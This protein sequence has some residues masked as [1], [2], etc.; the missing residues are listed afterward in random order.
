MLNIY[1][2]FKKNRKIIC[3][4][5]G[6]L[7]LLFFLSA[8]QVLIHAQNNLNSSL[9]LNMLL[10]QIDQNYLPPP[11]NTGIKDIA[12]SSPQ[13]YITLLGYAMRKQETYLERFPE[14]SDRFKSLNSEII[15]SIPK[16]TRTYN[17]SVTNN[18]FISTQSLEEMYYRALMGNLDSNFKQGY[19]KQ[20]GKDI[21]QVNMPFIFNKI[22]EPNP[23]KT[24]NK[25]DRIILLDVTAP[26]SKDTSDPEEI[27][28]IKDTI[29]TVDTEPIQE[30]NDP[31]EIQEY[32]I[33]TLKCPL[34]N[35]DKNANEYIE[36]DTNNN[37]DDETY[38]RCEYDPEGSLTSQTSFTEGLRHGEQFNFHTGPLQVAT[39]N[40]EDLNGNYYG[41]IKAYKYWKNEFDIMSEKL[42]G[43]NEDFKLLDE[44]YTLKDSLQPEPVI[45]SKSLYIKGI[46]TE[47]TWFYNNGNMK[48]YVK[49]NTKDGS[50]IKENCWNED[51][52]E[53]PCQKRAEK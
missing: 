29:F 9:T 1:P 36:I 10:T 2:G 27:T 20:F 22:E 45:S 40:T 14:Y 30:E 44:E 5:P 28:V 53:I 18:K 12:K 15:S 11:W 24:V 23:E 39:E 25:D 16:I 51:G 33:T 37:P 3:L 49:I 4:K 50:T 34:K 32:F 38:I 21:S 46:K 8:N 31:F 26:Y 13:L 43:N 47:T 6:F 35:T 48:R 17:Q 42:F 41:I 7:I 19:R 52:T